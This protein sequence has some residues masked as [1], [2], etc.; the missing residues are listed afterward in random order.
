MPNLITREQALAEAVNA[1]VNAKFL[2]RQAHDAASYTESQA[3]TSVYATASG[4]WSD[5]ARAYTGLAA[6]LPADEKLEA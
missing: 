3:R 6:Q 2:A 4:A 5:V 1:A